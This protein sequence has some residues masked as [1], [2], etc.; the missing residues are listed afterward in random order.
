[1]KHCSRKSNSRAASDAVWQ[2]LRRFRRCL[3]SRARQSAGLASCP[4]NNR[5]SFFVFNQ[6]TS[7]SRRLAGRSFDGTTTSTNTGPTG[8]IFRSISA[9]HQW[10]K[11][12]ESVGFSA[13]QANQ[14]LADTI[15]AQAYVLATNDIAW[16]SIWIFVALIGVIWI[17]RPAKRGA[18]LI[19]A[20]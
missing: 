18:G 14:S 2:L 16:A 10:L 20:E 8:R 12:L 5:S 17:A 19:A 13:S 9:T 6:N 1:M 11:H 4:R 7:V 3:G 15:Q